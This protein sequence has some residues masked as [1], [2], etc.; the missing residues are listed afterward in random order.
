[1]EL[2][3]TTTGAG[4]EAPKEDA[5]VGSQKKPL[6]RR[7]WL[8]LGFGEN[9]EK[10]G[11]DLF[12]FLVTASIPILVAYGGIR[13]TEQRAQDEALQAYL[14]EMGNLLLNG[15]LLTSQVGD[16]SRIVA[17]ARTSTVL[18]RLDGAHERSVVQFLYDSKLIEASSDQECQPTLVRRPEKCEPIVTL[19]GADLS[20]AD[21]TRALLGGANLSDAYLRDADL[22]N[23]HLRNVN[24]SG[25]DLS[26]ANLSDAYLGGAYLNGADLSGAKGVTDEN[27]KQAASSLAQTTMPDGS[28]R[29]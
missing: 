18:S 24:L 17:K 20:G 25:A 27:L 4:E 26:G 23:A 12:Q 10:T 5:P 19:N 16:E 2:D 7:L 8:W 15:D 9:G 13:F 11:L 21:L 29:D 3:N 28:K 1:M 14:Q 6:W 22:S